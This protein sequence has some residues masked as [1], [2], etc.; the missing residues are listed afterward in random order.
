MRVTDRTRITLHAEIMDSIEEGSIICSDGWAAYEGI[1]PTARTSINNMPGLRNAQGNFMYTDHQVVIH[2]KEFVRPAANLPPFWRN[3]IL[4][5][6][7]D[8]KFNGPLPGPL[9]FGTHLPFRVHTQTVERQ[10]RELRESVEST[11]D[12]ETVDRKIGEP[13]FISKNSDIKQ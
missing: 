8:M 1:M 12:L 9:Q 11:N 2:D 7:R 10:W 4:P 3:D 5:K 6:C 13:N